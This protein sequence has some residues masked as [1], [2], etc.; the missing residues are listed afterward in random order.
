MDCRLADGRDVMSLAEF[1]IT[2]L[3]ERVTD[4]QKI[5]ESSMDWERME[6]TTYCKEQHAPFLCEMGDRSGRR[7]LGRRNLEQ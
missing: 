2:L 4:D 3:G 6:S 1:P 5:V 7:V